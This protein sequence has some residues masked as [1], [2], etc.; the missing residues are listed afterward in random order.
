MP[1]FN[2]LIIACCKLPLETTLYLVV[3]VVILMN[4][5]TI[6]QAIALIFTHV[7]IHYTKIFTFP[8]GCLS[9]L[10]NI[11]QKQKIYHSTS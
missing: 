1:C 8:H 4:F 10:H 2:V 3:F 5:P 9:V 7:E 11:K 6:V